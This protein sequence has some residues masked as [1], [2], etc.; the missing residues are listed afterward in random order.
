VCSTVHDILTI[1]CKVYATFKD[2]IATD[3]NPQPSA[4]FGFYQP[5]GRPRTIQKLIAGK[6]HF[7]CEACQ[8]LATHN[9]IRLKLA[10]R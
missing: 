4:W 8:R 1:F 6:S 7:H 2:L 10:D 3:L 9:L 5:L